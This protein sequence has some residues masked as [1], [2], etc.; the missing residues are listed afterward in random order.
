[1]FL[2]SVHDSRQLQLLDWTL[3]QHIQIETV[4]DQA[5]LNL[6]TY[7]TNPDSSWFYTRSGSRPAH[8]RFG[9][10][11]ALTSTQSWTGCGLQEAEHASFSVTK[12]DLGQRGTGSQLKNPHLAQVLY[13]SGPVSALTRCA[14]GHWPR[15]VM[16]IWAR[17]FQALDLIPSKRFLIFLKEVIEPFNSV[18]LEQGRIQR[19]Q[20]SFQTPAINCLTTMSR[21]LLGGLMMRHS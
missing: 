7:S 3:L 16:M 12:T 1:M 18:V 6:V 9:R 5:L 10:I 19:L 20:D 2:V 14:K 21:N 4:N 13:S 15:F 17:T 11:H 8:L